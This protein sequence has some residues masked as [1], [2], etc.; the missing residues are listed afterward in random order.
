MVWN[1]LI[2]REILPGPD[3]HSTVNLTGVPRKNLRSGTAEGRGSRDIFRL[4][5]EP[6]QFPRKPYRI[7]RLPRSSRPENTYQVNLTG[8]VRVQCRLNV[9]LLRF[10]KIRYVGIA[11][12]ILDRHIRTGDPAG[13]AEPRQHASRR[14]RIPDRQN[15]PPC[16]L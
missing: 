10:R 6:V 11:V 9:N 5:P 15:P 14:R 1:L 7:P 2:L 3:I 8:L 13:S 4:S 12:W 16:R